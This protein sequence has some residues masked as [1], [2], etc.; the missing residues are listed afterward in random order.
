MNK[1][2][3]KQMS[4]GNRC[5]DFLHKGL[6]EAY[7]GIEEAFT[8]AEGNV[9]PERLEYFE[10]LLNTYFSVER[11]IAHM[12]EFPFAQHESDHQQLLE[13]FKRTESALLAMRKFPP[14]REGVLSCRFLADCLVKHYKDESRQLK[15]VLDTH[16]YDLRPSG[17]C[18]FLG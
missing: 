4:V 11:D 2:W 8:S 18:G 13:N 16:F 1:V 6:L 14:D 12:I 15:L 7:R 10:G 5:I 9:L 3:T 17:Q